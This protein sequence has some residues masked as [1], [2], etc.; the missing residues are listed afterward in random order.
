M[1]DLYQDL[2]VKLFKIYIPDLSLKQYKK[3]RILVENTNNTKKTAEYEMDS[4]GPEEKID[5][6]NTKESSQTND[7]FDLDN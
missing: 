5:L 4:S 6:S 7:S 1:K 3:R 2:A